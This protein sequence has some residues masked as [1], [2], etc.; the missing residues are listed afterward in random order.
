MVGIFALAL[1]HLAAAELV[2]IAES[3]WQ[4]EAVL[5]KGALVYLRVNCIHSVMDAVFFAPDARMR[6]AAPPVEL[7]EVGLWFAEGNYSGV[8]GALSR[9]LPVKLMRKIG[10]ELL[11]ARVVHLLALLLAVASIVASADPVPTARSFAGVAMV[12]MLILLGTNGAHSASVIAGINHVLAAGEI[13][14]L[15]A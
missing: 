12:D 6:A 13:G 8:V 11:D 2:E 7:S 3:G 1:L 4:L 9:D 5:V 14:Q 10:G 15:V